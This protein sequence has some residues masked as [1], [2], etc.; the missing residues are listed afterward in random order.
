MMNT[1]Q[2]LWQRVNLFENASAD[3]ARRGRLLNTMLAGMLVLGFLALIFT[4][5]ILSINESWDKPGNSLILLTLVV[6]ISASLGLFFVNQRSVN[7]ASFL[8]LLVLTLVLGFSDSPSEVANGRSS[9]VFFIPI[10]I[11][12]LLL[13]PVSSF[14]FAFGTSSIVILLS[15]V[16]DV[17]VNV[18]II[19]GLF[20]LALIS[21]L[22]SRSLEQ[23]LRDL[24]VINT[25]LDHLVTQRTQALSDA[26]SR[27]RIESGRNQAILNS[28]ADGVIVFDSDNHSILANPALSR[29]T[30]TSLDNLIGIDANQFINSG[31]ISEVNREMLVEF[32]KH[33]EKNT[34]ALRVDW[35]KNT[36]STSI[37]PVQT[38]DHENIGTVTVFRDITQEAQ[39]E[40]MKDNFV[41]IISHELR[42][43]LNAIMGHAEIMKEAVYGPL[44]EKQLSITQRIMVNVTRLLSMVGD[45][46]DEAQIRAGKL[47]IAPQ[48]FKVSS[49]LENLHNSMDKTVT[50]KGLSL[51]SKLGDGVPAEVVGDP[52]RIQQILFNLVGNAIKFTERG[53]IEVNIDRVDADNWKLEV[54]DHGIGIPE[55]ELPFI[56]DTFRQASHEVSTRQ[57]GGFGL[58]LSIVKQLVELMGGHIYV[59]SESGKGST[60]TVSLPLK[61]SL[62]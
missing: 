18:P 13:S 35:G 40:R 60:F 12:S 61:T 5:T 39:L 51:V 15:Y 54:T 38:S 23:A 20:F 49:L 50:D 16:A 36:F 8:F 48:E 59:K 7:F 27:E 6:L 9:F 33:P 41:A 4:I 22:S 11:S 19:G 28:I 1:L 44:N 24:R 56:F 34:S 42:T 32:I 2:N 37:A 58:G 30:N 25:N 55:N 17:S 26:L 62:L 14:F 47:S 46:L 31:Q 53:A 29:L 10:A 45:L 43:P 21:W 52:Q 57:H 3:D